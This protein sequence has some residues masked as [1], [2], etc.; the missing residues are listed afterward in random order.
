M[1]NREIVIN[2]M[3]SGNYLIEGS[4]IGHEI[5]NLY[6]ADDGKNYIYLNAQ[7]SID[8]SQHQDEITILLIR[9]LAPRTYKILAKAEGITIVDSANSKLSQKE[10]GMHQVAL[11]I[12]YG[13]VKLTDLFNS[14]RHRGNKEPDS[15]YVTFTANKVIKPRE[16]ICITDD[17]NLVED[18]TFYIRTNNGFGKQ[19]LREFYH[20]KNK[21]ESF[22]D[23]NKIIGNNNLWEEINTTQK[24][25]SSLANRQDQHFNILKIIR[26]EDSELVFSNMLA[27]FF[28][29]N[30]EVFTQFSRE[31]LQVNIKA[32]FI[33]EREKNNIDLLISDQNNVI[34]IENKIKSGINGIRHDI[35]SEEY[36]SQLQK[37]Y[38]FAKSNKEYRDKNI[39]CFIFSPNYNHINLERFTYGEKYTVINYREIYEFFNRHKVTFE[40]V[41]YYDDFINATYK[42]SKDYDNDLEEEM[43]RR[44]QRTIDDIK[45]TRQTP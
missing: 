43:Q 39:S 26:Q 33:I 16:Q 12:T 25:S 6:R 14:N 10:R 3:Y 35:Y 22:I 41:K 19:T 1:K 40:G 36:Q 28:N 17:S 21:P 20:E 27:Y 23:L 18:S 11:E 31:I 45:R 30:K 34:V 32:E 42:H 13:G 2:K 37:Y 15:T 7:G 5:I 38:N 29:Y 24:I 8:I 9:R 4:N 44:F